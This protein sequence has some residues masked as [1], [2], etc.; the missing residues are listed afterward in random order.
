MV[1][2]VQDHVSHCFSNEDGQT[3]YKQIKPLLLGENKVVVSFE[4]IDSVT[5]S[6]VNSAFIELLDSLGFSEIKE[7]L[8]FT[9][10]N[11]QINRTIKRRFKFETERR[12]ES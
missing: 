12:A 7:R 8:S 6:F 10:S 2:K 5:S 11:E 3:I 1:V 9:D 4:G